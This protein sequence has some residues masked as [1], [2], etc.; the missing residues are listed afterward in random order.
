MDSVCLEIVTPLYVIKQTC[1]GQ[2]NS[3]QEFMIGLVGVLLY[4][5][6]DVM[7]R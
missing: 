6:A 2:T 4:T 5:H 3:Q 7:A 1:W